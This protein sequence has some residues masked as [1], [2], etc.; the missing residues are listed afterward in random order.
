MRPPWPRPGRGH[1]SRRGALSDLPPYLGSNGRSP[2]IKLFF[3]ETTSPF[4]IIAP[5][6]SAGIPDGRWDV[7]VSRRLSRDLDETPPS[8]KHRRQGKGGKAHPL[9][10]STE[11]R[12]S[13]ERLASTQRA[14][15]GTLLRVLPRAGRS[16]E[17][18]EAPLASAGGDQ[19]FPPA[20]D[21]VQNSGAGNVPGSPLVK[22]L[23]SNAEEPGSLVQ[24]LV[25]ELKSQAS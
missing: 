13:G 24:S 4:S 5:F 16:S 2:L 7:S 10:T 8:S 15:N 11:A 19:P 12:C 23:P 6:P 21:G 20:Q 17:A 9:Q 18:G 22:N 14:L 1:H 3:L 25:R